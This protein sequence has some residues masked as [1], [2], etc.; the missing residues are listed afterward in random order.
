[1]ADDQNENRRESYR[2]P[3]PEDCRLR[4]Q[5]D[6]PMRRSCFTG[7]ITDMSTT[8]ASVLLDGTPAIPLELDTVTARF[9][10]PGIF[11]P[12]TVNSSIVRRTEEE[13]GIYLRL[14]FLPLAIPSAAE[15]RDKILW[16]FLLDE[17]RRQRRE[18]LTKMTSGVRLS[19]F[20]PGSR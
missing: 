20:R 15:S 4:V 17:Q 8:G 9:R 2:C 1:M 19:L 14:E 3:L 16:S 7:V 13:D 18:T 11:S 5:L 6:T 10:I 12:L